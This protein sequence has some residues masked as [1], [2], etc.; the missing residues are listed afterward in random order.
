[1]YFRLLLILLLV[2]S[3]N[4]Y[5][6]E[7]PCFESQL[8]FPLQ[9]QHVHSS[10]IVECS[11]GDLIACWFQG[12]GERKSKDVVVMGARLRQAET[13]WS[14]PFPMA[15]TP[16]FPDCNPVLFID[17]R[18]ELW[19]FWIAVFAERW[20]DSVLRCRRSRDYLGDGPPQ[21][22]WQ[23]MIA[24]DPGERFSAAVH[25]GFEQL[26]AQLP[27]LPLDG[28]KKHLAKRDLK[29]IR[30]ESGNLSL[31]QRGWMTRSRPLILPS[32]RYILPLYSDGSLLG[33]MALSD[34][35]GK[36]WR[37]S[38]PI[39][40]LALNQ[41]SL[42]RKQDGTLAA[43]M[44]EENDYLHRILCSE[45]TDDGETWS[46]AEATDMPNPNAS[47]EALTLRDGRWLLLYNDSETARDTLLLAMSGDEGGQWSWKRHLECEPGGQFHYPSMIEG[48]DGRVHI[49]YTFQPAGN[50]GKSIKHV[51]LSPD[52]VL[53]VN[54]NH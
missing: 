24:F 52:W 10:S 41:P 16:D 28:F 25:A 50:K 26:E 12:S 9:E 20:E 7:K 31:R 38:E 36:T 17:D 29:R 34:D 32:G 47:V 48:R 21:W 22:Y 37:P 4:T 35:Q 30:Q 45:S 19:L 39:V 13:E 14:V 42:A 33:L 44:R 5:A 1:M 23:D 54:A 43:Y 8:L 11:N 2:V 46:L 27:D 3:I 6:E 51:S 15:D 53:E 18:S 40:G 49:T